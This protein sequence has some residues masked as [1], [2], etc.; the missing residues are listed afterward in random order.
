MFINITN[1]NISAILLYCFTAL[2]L[3]PI[4]VFAINPLENPLPVGKLGLWSANIPNYLIIVAAP[5]FLV[6]FLI[7][8]V[9]YLTSMGNPESSE[10]AKNTLIY[11]VIGLVV[12]AIGKTFMMWF[13]GKF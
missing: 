8:G 2:L 4:N 9:Q 5:I 11:G 12:V 1:K 7:G 13:V 6:V 3:S 10:K